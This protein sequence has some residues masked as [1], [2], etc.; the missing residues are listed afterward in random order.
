M[1][2][3]QQED[4]NRRL[5][6]ELNR[7]RQLMMMKSSGV[8]KLATVDSTSATIAAVAAGR[9]DARAIQMV[10]SLDKLS[11]VTYLAT[12]SQ[13]GNAILVVFPRFIDDI[14]MISTAVDT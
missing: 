14:S 6:E 13:F 8:N 7:K 5:L 11:P 1:A 4:K 2:A 12:N 3:K 10:A 9:P